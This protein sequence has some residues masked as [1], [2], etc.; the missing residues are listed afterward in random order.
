[1]QQC[2]SFAAEGTISSRESTQRF[3]QTADSTREILG[4]NQQI[5][6][7]TEE[8]SAVVSELNLTLSHLNDGIRGVTNNA[9]D[10]AAASSQLTELAKTL[11]KE[12][13]HF[14]V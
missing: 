2:S 9:R 3:S 7:A 8:Q 1:M 13:S 5:A 6:T 10:T 4:L 12:A 14:K 11:R